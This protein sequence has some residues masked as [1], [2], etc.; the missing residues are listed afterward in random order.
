MNT[1]VDKFKRSIKTTAYSRFFASRRYSR[2]NNFSL[3][4]LSTSSFS[5]IFITLMQKYSSGLLFQSQALE[6]YQLIS[7]IFIAALSLVVA[8]ANYAINSYK[9]LKSGEEINFL[10]SLF[11]DEKFDM[12][13]IKARYQRYKE[14][15][16][17]HNH[18]DYVYGR[19]DRKVEESKTDEKFNVSLYVKIQYFSPFVLYA[20]ISLFFILTFIYTLFSYYNNYVLNDYS[21]ALFCNGLFFGG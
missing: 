3:F 12:N 19:R 20:A 16:D 18:I 15:S 14:K 7:S 10:L 9:M 8:F 5:L 21:N 11:D 4:A 2:L 1:D 13:V 17:N 6:L